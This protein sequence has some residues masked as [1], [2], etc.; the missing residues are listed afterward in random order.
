M[1]IWC[2]M[3]LVTEIV[4]PNV[5]DVK[6]YVYTEDYRHGDRVKFVNFCVRYCLDN[7]E[8]LDGWRCWNPRKQ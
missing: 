5:A 4:E 1:D 3:G 2:I 8:V 6:A 7:P